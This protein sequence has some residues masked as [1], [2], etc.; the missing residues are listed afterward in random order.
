MRPDLRKAGLVAGVVFLLAVGAVGI[1][2]R[3]RVVLDD[4]QV[5]GSVPVTILAALLVAAL[6]TTVVLLLSGRGAAAQLPGRERKQP[7]I[8]TRLLQLA[9]LALA[10]YLLFR[11]FDKL[12]EGFMQPQE[13]APAV[14]PDGPQ[15]EDPAEPGGVETGPAWSWPVA[16]VAGIILATVMALIHVVSRSVRE[17]ALPEGSADLPAAQ[18]ERMV[19]A[20][21]AALA[22]VD[23]P[24]AA[25]IEAYAAMERTLA[26]HGVVRGAPETPDELLQRAAAADLFTPRGERAAHELIAL[27]QRARFSERPLPGDA[28]DAAIEAFEVLAAELRQETSAHLGRQVNR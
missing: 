5:S 11:N 14:S 7:G 3:G 25:V 26:E 2:W 4:R 15:G 9:V 23:E 24:R 13:P 21:L 12:Q 19:T 8:V 27:F 20:G 10:L 16:L 1:G 22:E 17:P 28:R 18:V 6:V